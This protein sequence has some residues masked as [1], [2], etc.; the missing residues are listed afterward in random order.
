M[1][2]DYKR[3]NVDIKIG[4]RLEHFG[5]IYDDFKETTEKSIDQNEYGKENLG[6]EIDD[7]RFEKAQKPAKIPPITKT[8]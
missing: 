4:I 3:K 5:K 2:S 6:Q 8:V 7:T 1:I